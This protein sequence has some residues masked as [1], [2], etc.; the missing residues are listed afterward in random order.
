MLSMPPDAAFSR[1][2]W[3]GPT[4]APTGTICI[5]FVFLTTWMDQ[6]TQSAQ[7]WR[8]L[9]FVG[10]TT[11]YSWAWECNTHCWV[12]WHLFK[13]VDNT[14]PAGQRSWNWRIWLG[15]VQLNYNAGKEGTHP[16][17]VLSRSFSL[18]CG[19][20]TQM[21][22]ASGMIPWLALVYSTLQSSPRRSTEVG[23]W[24]GWR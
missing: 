9:Y 4:I 15:G 13:K 11:A 10:I 3:A 8:Y 20:W 16:W 22:W 18:L 12:V 2:N 5:L 1:T 7:P 21:L 6:P 23:L 24:Y 14:F 17:K 19:Y